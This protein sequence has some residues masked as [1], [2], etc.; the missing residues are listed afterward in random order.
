MPDLRVRSEEGEPPDNRRYRVTVVQSASM[1]CDRTA[2]ET[3]R[4]VDRFDRGAKEGTFGGTFSRTSHPARWG[5]WASR[6]VDLRWTSARVASSWRD[7]RN[8]WEL[9]LTAARLTTTRCS[10]PSM[11]GWHPPTRPRSSIRPLSSDGARPDRS[12]DEDVLAIPEGRVLSWWR[13]R[14]CEA[15]EGPRPFP[16]GEGAQAPSRAFWRSCTLHDRVS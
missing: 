8:G 7:P 2:P 4:T 14:R 16:C 11:N 6:Q 10:T 5:I 1:V 9:L 12:V 3:D 15:G 13:R